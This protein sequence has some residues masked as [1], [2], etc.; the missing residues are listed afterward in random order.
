MNKY[1]PTQELTIF[2]DKDFKGRDIKGTYI[3]L[4][5]SSNPESSLLLSILN[6][7]SKSIHNNLGICNLDIELMIANEFKISTPF[8]L[9]YKDDK[10]EG[11]YSGH[12]TNSELKHFILSGEGLKEFL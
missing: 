8:I 2:K 11:I 1:F 9:S 7:L 12:K 3:I 6:K 10:I 5:Y 4:F